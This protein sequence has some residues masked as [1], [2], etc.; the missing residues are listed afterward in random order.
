[1]INTSKPILIAGLGSIGR[2]HLKNLS[3][4]GCDN[5]ILYRTGKSTLPAEELAGYK[6]FYDLEEA[7]SLN[8]IAAI[9]SGPTSLH[10]SIALKAIKAGCHLFLEKPI[11][12]SLEGISE[13]QRIAKTKTLQIHVG[14]QFR[15]HP[16]LQQIKKW[17]ES[18]R[19]GQVISARSHWGEC[20]K[21]WHLWEDY[22]KS[23]S[24]REEMGGGVVL[25]LS[26]PFDYLI[27][28]LGDVEK[29]YAV[30]RKHQNLAINTECMAETILHFN[31][32]VIGSVYLD[33]LERPAKHTLDIIGDIGTIRWDNADGTAKLFV[34]NKCSG[35]CAVPKGFERNTMFL[36][37]MRHFLMC[38]N[39]NSPPMCSI[40]EGIKSL[41]I[42][43]AV[44]SS[45]AKGAEVNI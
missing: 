37:E 34:E 30:T 9:V 20:I 42:A 12:H 21:D 29:V 27:W 3:M 39:E 40:D 23:Y 17:I 36:E 44:K 4:V 14:F 24:V 32:G 35:E 41:E 19:I 25:T 38:I 26:H 22:R 10:I 18:N 28:L 13:L 2:R 1:M 16:G 31:S 7:L 33:Y 45:A 11:S 15:F 8:P 5:I 6:T 43:L